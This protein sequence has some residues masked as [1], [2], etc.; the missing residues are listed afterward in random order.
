MTTIVNYKTDKN[1][2]YIGRGSI[3]GNPYVIGK[4]GTRDEVINRYRDEWFPFLLKDKRFVR[5]LLKLKDQKLGCFCYPNNRCHGEVIVNY[6]D[7]LPN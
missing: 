6:F 4:D 1:C 2:C 3:F 5:E 7:S